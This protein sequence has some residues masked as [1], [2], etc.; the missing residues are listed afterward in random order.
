[1]AAVSLLGGAIR[2]AAGGRPVFPCAPGGKRPL[3]VNGLLD[4]TVDRDVI[5]RWW[6][7]WPDANLAVRTGQVSRLVVIDV[8]GDVGAESLCDL[9]REHGK[10]PIT[11]S[12]VTPR[13]GQHFYF[14][15]PGVEVRNSA[16]GL[17]AALDVRGDGGYVVVPP[18]VGQ[19]GRRYEPDERAPVAP[20]PAWLLERVTVQNGTARTAAPASAWIRMVRDGLPEGE[21]NCG[22]ARL[23]GHLLRRSIDVDLTSVLVHLVNQ[24]CRSPL[25]AGEVDRIIDNIAGREAR[26]PRKR[27]A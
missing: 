9:E 23:T 19:S 12:V 14:Q 3:S 16:G 8:D 22:L 24:R 17:G 11:T 4:A 15:H 7:R 18:S 1:M 5:E 26:R 10:L 27:R 25:P 21:R 2:L 6:A 20:M 13:G